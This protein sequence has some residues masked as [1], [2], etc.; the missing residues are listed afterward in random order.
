MGLI[1]QS[2]RR[3]LDWRDH[4]DQELLRREFAWSMRWFRS[5]S[6][7]GF[8]V[9]YPTLIVSVRFL[10]ASLISSDQNP[11]DSLSTLLVWYTGILPPVLLLFGAV[12]LFQRRTMAPLS[13][14]EL[15][16][17]ISGDID[18]RSIWPALLTAPVLLYLV[19]GVI[20]MMIS[21]VATLGAAGTMLLRIPRLML[22][23]VIAVA[24]GAAA[25]AFTAFCLAPKG[26][27]LRIVL[28]LFL[29]PVVLGLL[30]GIVVG[31]AFTRMYDLNVSQADQERTAYILFGLVQ[32]ALSLT[33]DGALY[34]FSLRGLRS[35]R[36]WSRLRTAA[37]LT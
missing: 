12:Y 36:M 34:Y 17:L 32:P 10:R 16:D 28:L 1:R 4:P 3:F 18:R 30:V 29:T 21:A 24:H 14:A 20:A 5:P 25:S 27:W 26:D 2:Q 11:F 6:G 13:K 15:P 31:V 37:E 9:V 19:A 23:P 33:L 35:E 8:L 7:S 22:Y